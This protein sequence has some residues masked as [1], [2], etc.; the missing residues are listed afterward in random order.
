MDGSRVEDA[1]DRRRLRRLAAGDRAALA[2][3]Y[4]A[5]ASRLFGLALW[6]TGR[7]SEAE[8]LVQE[9]MVKL[10][11]MGGE[12][13]SVRRP[14]AYLLR[15]VRNAALDRAGKGGESP[16]GSG[17]E[18]SSRFLRGGSNDQPAGSAAHDLASLPGTGPDA[19]I[20][21]RAALSR[22]PAEQRE[23]VFLHAIEGL[24]FREVGR[25]A[26]VSTFTAASRY[27]LALGRMRAILAAPAGA[28]PEEP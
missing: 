19:S 5:H 11:G 18:G 8:D 2:E 3:I 14:R 15:M 4:D 17:R 9:T 12:L 23:V 25:V 22:L 26:G 13:L 1:L 24:T 16:E 28:L 10:A 7:R 27:R 21:L 20:D 6:L